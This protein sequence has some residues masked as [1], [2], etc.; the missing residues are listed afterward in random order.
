MG[1]I[2]TAE[3]RNG[4]KVEIDGVPYNIV[5]FQHVKPGKGGAFVRTKLKSLKDGRVLERTFRSGEKLDAPDLTYTTMQ[6]LYQ[7]GDDYVFMDNSTY[8][9][10]TMSADQLGDAV[11]F[12]VENMEVKV[13]Y[14]QNQPIDVEIPNFLDLEIVE[15]DPGVRGDTA[16]GGSK[17][18]KVSTGAVVKVPLYIEVGERIK[19]DTRTHSYIERA[20]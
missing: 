5:E 7:S 16:S 1:T 11:D 8:D 2:S 12:M 15:T 20:K 4:A 6:Y 17:P 10:V 9:Q 18:A 14:H 3:F 13:L 19:V